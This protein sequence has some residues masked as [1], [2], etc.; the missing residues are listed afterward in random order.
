MT[1][2]LPVAMRAMRIAAITDSVPLPSMRNISTFGMCRL[3]SRAIISSDS[4]SSPVTGPHSFS[5]SM[6]FSRMTG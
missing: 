3:I 5:S 4:C 6:T 1:R 2:F